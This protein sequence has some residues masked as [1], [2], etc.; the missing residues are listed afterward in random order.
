MPI[1]ASVLGRTLGEAPPV[2]LKEGF[3]MGPLTIP[4]DIAESARG[5][6]A[7][8]AWPAGLP[9]LRHDLE[10]YYRAMERLADRMFTLFARALRLPTD[11]FDG[12][13]RGHNCTAAGP[14]TIRRRPSPRCPTSCAAGPHTDYG[15]FTI[16]LSQNAS[17]GLQVRTRRGAWLDIAR[18]RRPSS[19]ISAT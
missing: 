12:A 7:A 15:A 8:N 19:S 5:Y 3:G 17:G 6:Y 4:A 14:I 18:R 9:Q 16:L 2:D 10:T 11:F 13:L 1:G